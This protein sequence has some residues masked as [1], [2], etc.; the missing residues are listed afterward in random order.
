MSL[1]DPS[2]PT[3]RNL[4]DT[5][6][7]HMSPVTPAEDFRTIVLNRVSWAAVLAGVVVALVTQL[8]LN[9]LGLGIGIATL[10]SGT[11]DNPA[12]ST[13]SIGDEIW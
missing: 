11:G 8:L 9:M 5:D 3:P 4:G 6:A 13:F 7:P 2:P 10:D 12:A 1:S